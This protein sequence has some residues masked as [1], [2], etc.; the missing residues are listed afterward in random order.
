M[1][2]YIEMLKKNENKIEVRSRNI[3]IATNSGRS[4]RPGPLFGGDVVRDRCR[5]VM[6]THLHNLIHIE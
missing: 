2:E 6:F 3:S 5:S 4:Y 1:T